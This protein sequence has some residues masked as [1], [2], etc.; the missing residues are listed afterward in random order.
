MERAALYA[1]ISVD[2]TGE[3]IGVSRQS[4]RHA[5]PCRIPWL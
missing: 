1:R 4:A 3:E 5:C 2:K